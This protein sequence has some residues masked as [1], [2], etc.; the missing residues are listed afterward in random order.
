MNE[1]A[2]VMIDTKSAMANALARY[3]LVV[4]YTKQVMKKDKDYGVIPGA[5]TKPTLLKPGAEKLCNL[6]ELYP[7]FVPL[8]TTVD[9]ANNMFYFQYRCDLFNR[10]TGTQAGSGIGSCNSHEKKYRYRNIPEK[11]ATD[12]E[13]SIALRTETKSGKYGEYRVLVIENQDPADLLNT[14]DKM[15]QKRALIAATLIACNASEFFTQDIEDMD[16][17]EG[18]FREAVLVSQP[19]M[20]EPIQTEH[21]ALPGTNDG[22][23]FDPAIKPQSVVSL[24]TASAM[25]NKDGVRYDALSNDKLEWTFRGCEKSLKDPKWDDEKRAELELKR[26]AAAVV[27]L[28]RQAAS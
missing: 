19:P 15:A 28:S 13:K 2:I 18:E 22:Y 24:E 25:L 27:Y 9:F 21:D 10:Q 8:T 1:N 11:K 3:N 16:I 6:F 14:I 17:I 23:H 7:V 20:P 12:Y 26:D 5:G 4:E